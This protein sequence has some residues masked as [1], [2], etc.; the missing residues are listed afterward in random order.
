MSTESP[1]RTCI[2]LTSNSVLVREI[3][4]FFDRMNLM[5]NVRTLFCWSSTVSDC[6]ANWMMMPTFAPGSYTLS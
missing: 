5:S 4:F 1:S 2:C 6:A 3:V